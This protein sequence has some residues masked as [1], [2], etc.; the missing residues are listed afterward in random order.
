MKP[1]YW[2]AKSLVK[3]F[4]HL[5]YRHQVFGIQHIPQGPCILAPNHAS[6]FDPALIGISC[7]EE[8][9]FLARSTLFKNPV[10]KSL[11]SHLN[12]YP[13][14]ATG[15]DLTSIK[16][17]IQLLHEDKKVVIF[18]EG[19][20]SPNGDLL[21][22]KPG[23]GMLVARCQCPVVPIYIH[24]TFDIWPKNRRLPKLFGK[25]VCVF[26]SPIFWESYKEMTKKQAQEEITK[27]IQKSFKNLET[28]FRN[29]AVGQPP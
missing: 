7:H 4:F 10:L 17:I 13:I 11:I 25:T 26:G 18:P 12:S 24:G 22:V 9:S 1:F 20:R 3:G 19:R 21:P 5:F 14:T 16:I 28:W 27:A 29:G 6:F 8:V 23:I 2:L 15:H